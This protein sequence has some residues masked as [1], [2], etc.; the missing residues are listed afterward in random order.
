VLSCQVLDFAGLKV[1]FTDRDR[2]LKQVVEWAE[3]GTRFP[4]VV[5]GPEGCGK[6]SWLLQAVEALKELGFGAIYFNPLRKEFL[7]EVGVKS[8]EERAL[9]ALRQASSGHAL[10]KLVWGVIDLAKEAIKL[11]R[12]RLAVV[13]DDAFQPIGRGRPHSSSRAYLK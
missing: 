4:V 9:E 13:V 11:G 10:A 5:F 6:T 7:T 1:E 8:V 12:G 3:E 2:A